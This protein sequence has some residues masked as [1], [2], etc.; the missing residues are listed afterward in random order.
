[1]ATTQP[2]LDGLAATITEAVRIVTT[3]MRENNISEPTFASDS[4]QSYG[5]LPPDINAV[6]QRLAVTATDLWHLA[7]GPEDMVWDRS[8]TVG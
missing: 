3:H 8:W 1:M 7:L 4:P 2:T 6:R 5:E